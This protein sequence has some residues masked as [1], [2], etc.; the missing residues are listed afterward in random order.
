M[1]ERYYWDACVF[2]SY[3][4][5]MADRMETIDDLLS[6]SRQQQIQIVTSALSVVEVAFAATE[7]VHKRLDDNIERAIDNL[8]TD[9]KAIKLAEVHQLLVSK[10]RQ[11]IR[12]SV[13]KDWSLKAA[14]AIHLATA[15]QL[16]VSQ[17]HTYDPAWKKYET[18]IGITV[19]E[20]ASVQGILPYNPLS[21]TA[22]ASKQ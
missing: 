2:L 14:D 8:W 6:R 12:L 13:T 7:K 20:P 3:V 22:L 19:C 5:G 10:A 17:I 21:V 18:E 4:N 11:L 9:R 16:R 15:E 1:I